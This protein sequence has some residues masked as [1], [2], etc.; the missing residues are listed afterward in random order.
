MAAVKKHRNE[1]LATNLEVLLS[2]DKSH[3]DRPAFYI[4][5]FEGSSA[6][7]DRA[8]I[9]DRVWALIRRRRLR[10]SAGA[11]GSGANGT[12]PKNSQ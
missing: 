11:N 7:F 9:G 8:V 2:D 4:E 5:S 10:H 6:P 1:A 3:S 12:A